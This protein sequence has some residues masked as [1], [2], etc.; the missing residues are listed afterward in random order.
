MGRCGYILVQG[1]KRLASQ[2]DLVNLLQWLWLLFAHGVPAKFVAAF[3]WPVLGESVWPKAGSGGV[4]LTPPSPY[5]AEEPV[6]GGPEGATRKSIVMDRRDL[7]NCI[8]TEIHRLCRDPEV[9]SIGL[10]YMDHGSETVFGETDEETLTTSDFAG[11]ASTTHATGKP[12]LVIIDACN[13]TKFAEQVWMKLGGRQRKSNT[14]ASSCASGFG[15]LASGRRSTFSSATIVSKDPELVYPLDDPPEFVDGWV[16]GFKVNSSMFMRKLLWLL[17]YGLADKTVTLRDFVEE[18]NKGKGRFSHGFQ[19]DLVTFSAA[20]FA[21]T[22]LSMF[23]PFDVVQGDTEM[24][25]WAGVIFDQVIPSRRVGDLYDDMEKFWNQQGDENRFE[26]R[27]VEVYRDTNDVVTD[28]ITGLLD[29]IP[30]FDRIRGALPTDRGQAEEDDRQD[31]IPYVPLMHVY[32]HVF[33][34]ARGE[35]QFE[36]SRKDVEDV[37]LRRFETFLETI[38]GRVTPRDTQFV[39][40]LAQYE[41]GIGEDRVEEFRAKVKEFWRGLA[42]GHLGP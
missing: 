38:Y 35:G 33:L 36:R 23:F 1:C 7:L 12:L 22:P 18:L 41:I 42:D 29:E 39:W 13:S 27:F 25:D 9:E 3:L 4:A 37:Y 2:A 15:I 5:D 11:W 32:H 17:T 8:T 28:G 30:A 34:W 24:P 6:E 40:P 10:V 19:A 26:S 20:H 31:A 16:M 21:A 14:M